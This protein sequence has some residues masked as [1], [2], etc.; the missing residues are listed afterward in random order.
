MRSRSGER[1][2]GYGFSIGNISSVRD[3]RLS[4]CVG[5]TFV[6]SRKF[7]EL[8]TR[9]SQSYAR[10]ARLFGFNFGLI[11]PTPRFLRRNSEVIIQETIAIVVIRDVSL[12]MSPCVSRRFFVPTIRRFIN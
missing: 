2:D 9:Y 12:S 6:G 5:A 7:T 4:I 1:A 3:S 11:Y 8:T 10:K